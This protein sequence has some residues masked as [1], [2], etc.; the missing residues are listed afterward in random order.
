MILMPVFSCFAEDNK[1]A[2]IMA[3][4]R[5]NIEKYHKG[6]AQIVFKTKDDK[7]IEG[8]SMAI[9]QKSQDFLFGN[10][11]F[12]VVGVL[13]KFENIDVYR[14]EVFKKRFSDVFNMAIFPFYWAAYEE[15]AVREEW[16]SIT[17]I[18]D[19]CKLNDITPKGHPLAWVESGG[20]P[21]WLYD[22]PIETTEELLKGRIQR[23][24]KGFEG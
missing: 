19:W 20:T 17:P 16:P 5:E 4:A 6:N 3:Q 18:L 22:M 13:G 24:V 7:S 23:I 11:I 10:I 9:E 8:A 21:R 12:P 1:A 15:T 14:P 2:D